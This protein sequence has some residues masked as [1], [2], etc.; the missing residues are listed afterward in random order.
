M[1]NQNIIQTNP[2]GCENCR[3]SKL[4][5]TSGYY[6]QPLPWIWSKMTSNH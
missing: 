4:S 2:G 6:R 5:L 1:K 3:G